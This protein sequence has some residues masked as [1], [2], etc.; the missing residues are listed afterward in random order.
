MKGADDSVRTRGRELAHQER[1]VGA[2]KMEAA[3]SSGGRRSIAVDEE[4]RRSDGINLGST[5]ERERRG[6]GRTRLDWSGHV[7]KE[8]R[9]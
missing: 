6:E 4:L 3:P 7:R 5:V 8:Q 9:G 1:L 2:D